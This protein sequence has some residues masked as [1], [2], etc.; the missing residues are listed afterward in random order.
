MARPL[1]DFVANRFDPLADIFHRAPLFE[2]LGEP[3]DGLRTGHDSQ[4]GCQGVQRL[5]ADVV[6][7]AGHLE[8]DQRRIGQP[9][10]DEIPA[11]AVNERLRLLWNHEGPS[12]RNGERM[13][14]L[15]APGGHRHDSPASHRAASLAW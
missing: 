1:P 8:Q 14:Q 4:K 13:P 6:H 5:G 9:A 7:R 11:D 15:L 12:F 2:E 3:A 10:G